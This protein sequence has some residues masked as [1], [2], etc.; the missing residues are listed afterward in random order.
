MEWCTSRTFARIPGRRSG[1]GARQ[2][3]D[4]SGLV[5]FPIT[6]ALTT[7]FRADALPL[8]Y[9]V[10]SWTLGAWKTGLSTGIRSVAWAEDLSKLQS[11]CTECPVFQHTERNRAGRGEASGKPRCG[12]A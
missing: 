11:S 10:N 9:T 5:C 4:S 7:K 6:M 2:E 8:S 1:V 3:T 12:V